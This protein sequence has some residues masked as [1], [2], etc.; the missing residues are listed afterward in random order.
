VTV[1]AVNAGPTLS[2]ANDGSG[3]Y[4]ITTSGLPNQRYKIQS[5]TD[6][7]GNWTDYDTE[8]YAGSNG[9]ISWTD[10]DPITNH[11]SRYY[12]LAQY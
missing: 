11:G 8:V 7:L 2:G 10:S 6:G 9:L 12:R 5:S 1:N 3:H 4:Q